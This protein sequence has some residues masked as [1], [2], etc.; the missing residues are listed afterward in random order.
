M[1]DT[2]ANGKQSFGINEFVKFMQS[3]DEGQKNIFVL[4]LWM[5]AA[6]YFCIVWGF[7]VVVGGFKGGLVPL[8]RLSPRVS[9]SFKGVRWAKPVGCVNFY[10]HICG[11]YGEV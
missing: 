4:K 5:F 11:V 3:L 2:L 9:F 7:L 8:A 1:F 10:G 6:M